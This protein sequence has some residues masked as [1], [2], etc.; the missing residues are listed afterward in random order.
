MV[1]MPATAT[2]IPFEG[3]Q[4][5]PSCRLERLLKPQPNMHMQT[6]HCAQVHATLGVVVHARS[7]ISAH[8]GMGRMFPKR[9]ARPAAGQAQ[10]LLVTQSWRAR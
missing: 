1:G 2:G 4:P 7:I 5:A 3:L 8:S 9:G 6:L 10:G